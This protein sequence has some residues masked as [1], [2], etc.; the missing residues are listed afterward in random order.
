MHCDL[1]LILSSDINFSLNELVQFN[2]ARF[3]Q[4][5]EIK[6]CKARYAIKDNLQIFQDQIS[7]AN[8]EV[9]DTRMMDM[10]HFDEMMFN[11]HTIY[12]SISEKL[13]FWQG[14]VR[15]RVR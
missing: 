8:G 13:Q 14:V 4:K 15:K 10:S 12:K 7:L 2:N 3:K 11:I 6:L 1:K 9:P 5:R